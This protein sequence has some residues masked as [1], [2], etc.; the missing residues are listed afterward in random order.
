MANSIEPLWFV[1]RVG[2]EKGV[3]TKEAMSEHSKHV[4]KDE[5]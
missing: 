1:F 4:K 5:S 3:V 2:G